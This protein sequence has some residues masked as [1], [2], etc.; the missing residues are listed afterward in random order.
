MDFIDN[1]LESYLNEISGTNITFEHI[2]IIELPTFDSPDLEAEKNDF[3]TKVSTFR[4]LQF[5]CY[6]KSVTSLIK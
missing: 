4:I 6:F 5:I 3:D 2:N 1:S